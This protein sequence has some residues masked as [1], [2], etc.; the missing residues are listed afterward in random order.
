M[1]VGFPLELNPHGASLPNAMNYETLDVNMGVKTMSAYLTIMIILVHI[2]YTENKEKTEST[3]IL[4][5]KSTS[6]LSI[7]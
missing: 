3:T 1:H 5:F 6:T 2:K 4:S 7:I